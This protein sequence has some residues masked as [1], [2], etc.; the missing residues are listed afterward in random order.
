MGTKK[1]MTVLPLLSYHS[2]RPLL[3][4][5]PH[6]SLSLMPSHTQ[7]LLLETPLGTG[8]AY[9]IPEL[10]SRRDLLKTEQVEKCMCPHI[11]T[12]PNPRETTGAEKKEGSDCPRPESVL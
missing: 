2:R 9:S 5:C 8:W 11:Y 6:L 3:G 12:P 10:Q 4:T 7:R 1:S